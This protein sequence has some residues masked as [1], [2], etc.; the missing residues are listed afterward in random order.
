MASIVSQRPLH[1]SPAMG[2]SSVNC[3][4]CLVVA[5]L[6]VLQLVQLVQLTLFTQTKQL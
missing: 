2:K 5:M 6:A 1:N 4:I 3:L